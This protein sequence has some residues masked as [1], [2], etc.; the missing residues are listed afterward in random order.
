M[1]DSGASYMTSQR[2]KKKNPE[3]ETS[4]SIPMNLFFSKRQ[5]WGWD[6]TTLKRHLKD[7]TNKSNMWT[8]A[9]DSN[10]VTVNCKKDSFRQPEKYE[11]KQRIN[12]TKELFNFVRHDNGHYGNTRKRIFRD[13]YSSM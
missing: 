10:K 8:L 12:G 3:G 4:Y 13:A 7:L 1:K 9:P 11:Y 6:C 5:R 2:N